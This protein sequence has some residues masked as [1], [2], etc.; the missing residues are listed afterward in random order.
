MH[1][2]LPFR[3][4]TMKPDHEDRFFMCPFT[5]IT[6]SAVDPRWWFVVLTHQV[7]GLCSP[8]RYTVTTTVVVPTVGSDAEKEVAEGFLRHLSIT[9]LLCPLLSGRHWNTC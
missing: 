9:L 8:Y 1:V 2:L 6:A 3:V 7:H 4:C 5:S